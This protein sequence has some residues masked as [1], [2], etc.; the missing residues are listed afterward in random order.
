M[1]KGKKEQLQ[2]FALNFIIGLF[3]PLPKSKQTGLSDNQ[4][5]AGQTT[6]HSFTKRKPWTMLTSQDIP[7]IG[8]D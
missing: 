1:L 3:I 2:R 5:L 8:L 7:Y 6:P 4:T